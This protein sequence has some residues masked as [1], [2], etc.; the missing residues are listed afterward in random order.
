MTV[1]TTD[2]QIDYSSG[3]P[4]FPIPFKFL[5]DE[6]IRPVL[7]L[8][9]GSQVTLVQNVQFTIT[10][11]GSETGGT[12]ISAYAQAAL[13]T[14]GTLLRISRVMD[15]TQETDLR[16]QGRYFA[17]THERVFD[18]LTM[19]VQQSLAGV[20]NALSLNSLKNR[21]DFRGLRGVN[22]G[23]PIDPQDVT[24]KSYVDSSN[25]AQDSRIDSLSAGLPGTNYAFPWSTITTTGTKTLTPG[26]EFSSAV[27]YINGIAQTYGRAFAVAGNQIVLA[28]AIPAGTEV[29][30]ILGQYVVP[31]GFVTADDIKRIAV[32]FSMFPGIDLTGVSDSTA[33][34][35]AAVS[36][37]ATYITGRGII[38]FTDVISVPIG[39]IIEGHDQL[40]LLYD[41]PAGGDAISFA[42]ANSGAKY[43][44]G[45]RRTRLLSSVR[46]RYG[47]TTPKSA[48]AWSR[49]YRFDFT[50]FQSYDSSETLTIAV[51]YWDRVLN[52]G[53]FRRCTISRFHIVG[54]WPPTDT[55]GTDHANTGI[56]ISSFTGAIGLTINDGD[57]SSCSHPMV[58][59]DGVE[60]HEI[61]GIECVSCWDG[62]TY[63]NVSEEP[64]GFVDNCHFNA[65]HRGIVGNRRVE[66]QLGQNSCYRSAGMAV[67]TLG[68]SALELTNCNFKI[69][70]EN[71]HIVPSST[72]ALVDSW[73]FRFTNCAANFLHIKGFDISLQ[74]T[75][76]IL[77]DAVSGLRVDGGTA[78]GCAAFCQVLS[79][80]TDVK[81]LNIDA[82]N[83]DST[84]LVV[85]SG[86]STGGIL[87]QRSPQG[88]QNSPST[89]VINASS[90]FTIQPK[91]GI[92]SIS[93]SGAIT[94][95][96]VLSKVGASVGDII[97]LKYSNSSTAGATVTIL[98]GA[99]GTTLNIIRSGNSNRYIIR[100]RF[101]GTNWS[102]DYLALD[103]DATL[104]T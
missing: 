75:G 82:S 72:A 103:L 13:A 36:S 49:Q 81:M 14:A 6:D 25:A 16:N 78:R 88:S 86:Y 98:N 66:L 96:L 17:E 41:G 29:Y 51:N 22:A 52:L 38:R 54:G 95:N 90:D 63:S 91:S 69:T 58:L 1:S 71:F 56:Y 27:L 19:L 37:G 48:N 45:I 32:D 9:D 73:A 39:V 35:Q 18:K 33:A 50:G 74:M 34:L 67:H 76:V 93:P 43:L 26:F 83:A 80:A 42:E 65:S 11:A 24:T 61:T 44:S 4:S 99:A 46:G 7:T 8:A 101:S 21:W 20:A 40:K 60:G 77:L 55:N 5:R 12:L 47:V 102:C 62:L 57:F 100:Y 84:L 59:G 30:A 2:S 28:Q 3:G 104:R 85:P 79:T 64:G 87:L 94:A 68:W 15:P 92:T 89:L 53:D 10:G 23:N 31:S 70:V 97:E